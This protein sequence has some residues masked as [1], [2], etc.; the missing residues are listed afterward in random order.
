MIL[1][2][3]SGPSVNDVVTWQACTMAHGNDGI[4]YIVACL[5]APWSFYTSR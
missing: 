3:L 5:V 2:M 4:N 1:G